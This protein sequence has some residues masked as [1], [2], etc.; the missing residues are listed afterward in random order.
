MFRTKYLLGSMATIFSLVYMLFGVMSWVRGDADSRDIIACF[1]L[2]SLHLAAGSWLLLRSI[3]DYREEKRRIEA[4]ISHLIALRGGRV[5]VTEL[6]DLAELSEDD[7]REYLERRAQLDV[8]IRTSAGGGE[9]HYVFGGE[10][11]KN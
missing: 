2:G 8:V 4:V 10:Y 3:G 11:W 9:E 1:V 5:S 6:A 7:A